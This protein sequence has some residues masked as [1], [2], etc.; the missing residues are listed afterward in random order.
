MAEN[1][2]GDVLP[3]YVGIRYVI[4]ERVLDSIVLSNL[5]KYDR[6]TSKDLA[7]AALAVNGDV[8]KSYVVLDEY[9]IVA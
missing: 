2:L 9:T 8:N 5:Y 7:L 4:Y 6:Y 3:R 1:I